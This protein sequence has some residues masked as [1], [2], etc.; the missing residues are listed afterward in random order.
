MKELFRK[1]T[2]NNFLLLVYS[3]R[4][5]VRN[6]WKGGV[7]EAELAMRQSSGSGNVGKL[8]DI[9]VPEFRENSA[10]PIAIVHHHPFQLLRHFA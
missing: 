8:I 3:Q 7:Q 9:D 5:K 10:I 6:I 2:K 4:A 1:S